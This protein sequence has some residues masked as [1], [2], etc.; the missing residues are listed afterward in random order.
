M[1]WVVSDEFAGK[2]YAG[3]PFGG[4]TPLAMTR[5]SGMLSRGTT[6]TRRALG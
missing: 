4:P 3:S 6:K 2:G 5:C 1:A